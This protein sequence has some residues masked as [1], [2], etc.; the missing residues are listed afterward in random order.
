MFDTP[1]L[2]ELLSNTQDKLNEQINW[3]RENLKKDDWAI[4][5]LRLYK[6][7]LL[8]E[9]FSRM[10]L[11]FYRRKNPQFNDISS[12]KELSFV[13]KMTSA[14]CTADIYEL[15][16]IKSSL[17]HMVDLNLPVI[18]SMVF[19]WRTPASILGEAED[20][21]LSWQAQHEDTNLVE[22]GKK[23]IEFEDG[24]AWFDLEKSGCNQEARAMNHCGNGSGNGRQTV[25]SY[26]KPQ[27]V[28]NNGENLWRPY[29]T[30]ILDI[31]DGSLG[32]MKGRANTKPAERYHPYILRLLTDHEPIDKVV[33]GGYLPEHNFQ[34]SDLDNDTYNNLIQIKPSLFPL[35]ELY[36]KFGNVDMIGDFNF[37]EEVDSMLGTYHQV[38]TG[39]AEKGDCKKFFVLDKSLAL[40]ELASKYAL[41][42]L[43]G[44]EKYI[45]G[46]DFFEPGESR[47]ADAYVDHKAMMHEFKAKSPGDYEKLIQLALFEMNDSY[48][49]LNWDLS[50]PDAFVDYL[51]ENPETEV[52]DVFQCAHGDAERDGAE[53]DMY[54]AID[55]LTQ[56]FFK[57]K[58]VH[59]I[60][61]TDADDY[62]TY[63]VAITREDYFQLAKD[64]KVEIEDYRNMYGGEDIDALKTLDEDGCFDANDLEVPYYGFSGFD[65][66]YFKG[67]LFELL[68]EYAADVN[69]PEVKPEPPAK[70]CGPFSTKASTLPASIAN[71]ARGGAEL[72]F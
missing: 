58:N 28:N 48:L 61:D 14:N 5:Y 6:Y 55:K 1:L 53:S 34:L 29:L 52:S 18:N 10:E 66:D 22:Y 32:E 50:D 25:L 59:L 7:S 3:T 21:E 24:S 13:R 20:H 68:R 30:F 33:G 57:D 42:T 16:E 37:G 36:E 56:D 15:N 47:W 38:E 64:Y 27:G 65:D 39:S 8:S 46:D 60:Q 35:G 69:I 12:N 11:D 45:S 4:W 2:K 70:P 67:R 40:S 54:K 72:S 63:H 44:Y 41:R 23:I 62:Y 49:E 71:K 17:K 51:N 19:N 31:E 43:E 9:H 26:R